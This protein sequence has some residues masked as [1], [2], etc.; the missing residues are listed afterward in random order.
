[1]VFWRFVFFEV[2]MLMWFVFGVFGIVPG[3]L[4]MLVF[5]FPNFLAFVGGLFLFILGLE[6]L[7]VFAFL[8]FVFVFCVVFVF[9]LFA[10][11]LCCF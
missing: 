1:M 3:V 6:G 7:G 11:F 10:L 4:K 2:L 5:F 9:V 8:V